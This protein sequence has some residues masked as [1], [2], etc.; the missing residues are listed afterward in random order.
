MSPFL[1]PAKNFRKKN[2]KYTQWANNFDFV[3]LSTYHENNRKIIGK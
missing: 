1:I 3:M 2:K